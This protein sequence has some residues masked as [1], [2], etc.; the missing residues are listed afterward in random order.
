MVGLVNKIITEDKHMDAITKK[1]ISLHITPEIKGF[2]YLREAI[3]V[4]IEKPI[5]IFGMTKQGGLY[6]AIAKKFDDTPSR[7]ERAMRHA[8]E[9]AFNRMEAGKVETLIDG[10]DMP[11]GKLTNSAFIGVLAEEIRQQVKIE[12]Q[13]GI[14]CAN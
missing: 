8:I 4:A 9:R 5:A 1:L 13:E 3:G 12:K 6:D 14:S 2:Y 10:V 7:V 11:S